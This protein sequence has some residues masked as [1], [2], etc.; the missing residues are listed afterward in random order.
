MENELFLA[1]KVAQQTNQNFVFNKENPIQKAESYSAFNIYQEAYMLSEN[2]SSEIMDE[3]KF[4]RIINGTLSTDDKLALSVIEAAQSDDIKNMLSEE[5]LSILCK[6]LSEE[7]QN[8]ENN[9]SIN[10]FYKSQ[11][12][13]LTDTY[14]YKGVSE[15][16]QEE[17]N[18]V[19]TLST[20]DN[21]ISSAKQSLSN[22]DESDG[23][24]KEIFDW[25]K[26][27]FNFGTSQ[28]DVENE[29][30]KYEEMFNELLVCAQNGEDFEST[31][32]KL[33][34]TDF[35]AEKISQYGQKTLELQFISMGLSKINN[36]NAILQ[37]DEVK[38][39]PEKTFELFTQFYGEEIGKE[40][41]IEAIKTSYPIFEEIT[42]D[43]NN[44]I[45]FKYNDG[46][47]DICHA[48]D[49]NIAPYL[50]GMYK[51]E[52]LQNMQNKYF[53]NL[54]DST[55]LDYEK[56]TQEYADISKSAL[57]DFSSVNTILN[58]YINSQENFIKNT[59]SVT[60]VLGICAMV[61]GGVACFVPGG[62]AIGGVLIKGG[63]SAALI[64]TFGDNALEF[65]DTSTN[66]N[67]YEENK[68]AYKNLLKETLVDGALFASGYT[69]GKI[70]GM[71]GNQILSKTGSAFL[72]KTADIGVDA[73][74]SLMSDYLITGEIDLRGE[75][76]N[77]ILSILTGTACARLNDTKIN[78][79]DT[80]KINENFE[81]NLQETA[82]TK[83]PS[84]EEI[85]E[86]YSKNP[87]DFPYMAKQISELS[88]SD[89]STAQNLMDRGFSLKAAY[90][91]TCEI[92]EFKEKYL[93]RI[94]D[95]YNNKDYS[96]ECIEKISALKDENYNRAIEILESGALQ[97]NNLDDTYAYNLSQVPKEIYEA[98]ISNLKTN[99]DVLNFLLTYKN[100]T[101]DNKTKPIESENS[102]EIPATLT[103]EEKIESLK[104][105]SVSTENIETV[106]K[107]ETTYNNFVKLLDCGI[108][109]TAAVNVAKLNVEQQEIALKL[110]TEYYI[111]TDGSLFALSS[112]AST[113]EPEAMCKFEEV[114]NTGCEANNLAEIANLY[115]QDPQEY[116]TALKLIKD[117]YSSYS[118]LRIINENGYINTDKLNATD[119]ILKPKNINFDYTNITPDIKQHLV[120]S[121]NGLYY[122]KEVSIDDTI[123]TIADKWLKKYINGGAFPTS[124]DNKTTNFLI[125]NSCK[126]YTSPNCQKMARWMSVD[127][128]TYFIN[129]IPDTGEIYTFDRMQS[130][131]KTTDGA[132]ITHGN[133]YY[134]GNTSKNVKIIVEPKN[135]LTQAYDTGDG[136]YG[137]DEVLYKAGA[138]F[139]IVSKNVEYIKLPNGEITMQYVIELK[140]T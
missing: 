120:D 23:V 19:Y 13:V 31:Y 109:Q 111:G 88:E 101:I 18:Y 112:I 10:E 68:E 71:L 128:L 137:S 51:E 97:K 58:E 130:F 16:T 33:T 76:F 72:Q 103:P 86:I 49:E 75:G 116:E 132:E 90:R 78:I 48:T 5:E 3:E 17:L 102:K 114:L 65:I 99:A 7:K 40:K 129:S 32:K 104:T 138:Q 123:D 1:T 54:K 53:E 46:T 25:T 8:N 105:R 14:L 44:Q 74:L 22:Q 82:P 38:N 118:I 20:L 85:Y 98:E 77:Q 47:Q 24:I 119:K 126:R 94:I 115:L 87:D 124:L 80:N 81:T 117:G 136:K 83:R 134:D 70:G 133:Q 100:K 84:Y 6:K 91:A 56:I 69:A 41:Y 110:A 139:T 35:D 36:F 11:M 67:T 62:Q 113:I 135:E 121:I 43:E 79:G 92:P 140:E 96:I 57:G 15:C 131:A 29:I 108:N 34:N 127:N 12:E 50:K 89:F 37:S 64:G 95:L 55:G 107:D 106:I 52:F 63:Q 30:E 93:E 28:K 122:S 45:T 39:N 42:I 2:N 60:Q 125:E 4:N 66:D 27:T 21:I 61:I 59:A 9:I 26:E 73:S